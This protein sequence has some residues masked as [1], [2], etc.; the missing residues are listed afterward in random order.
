MVT[1]YYD[2]IK[3][4]MSSYA[5]MYGYDLESFMAATGSSEEPVQE[6]AAQAAREIIA[7]KA[8]A[9]AEDLNVTDEEVEAELQKN[10]ADYGYDDV[11]EYK[12]A[13]DLKGYKEYMMTEKVLSFL[14]DNA[15]VTDTEP[16]QELNTEGT[17]ETATQTAE[18]ETEGTETAGTETGAAEETESAAGTQAADKK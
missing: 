4:N 6:S 9:D 11:E 16:V 5:A 13:I 14:F 8:I 18:T 3:A 15:V 17:T 1:R 12:S 2:R 7:M 10:A